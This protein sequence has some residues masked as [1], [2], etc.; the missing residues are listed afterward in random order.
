M[1]IQR[2]QNEFAVDVYESHCRI[3]LL[4]GDL[5][6]FNQCQTQ[7]KDLYD[8][9]THQH[10]DEF[11]A[12][13]LLYHV[14]LTTNDKYEAASLEITKLLGHAAGPALEHA[15]QVRHAV[16]LSDY[17]QFFRLHETVPNLG[18]CLTQCI[19]PTM[20]LRAMKR[21]TR[22]YRPSLDL[23]ACTQWLG[24]GSKDDCRRWIESC[25]GKT[26]ETT[27][28]TKESD[29]AIHEPQ[30]EEKNSLI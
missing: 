15:L 6:E 24:L 28:L 21:I 7:L 10:P 13:R 1:T 30:Q 11:A 27:F 22:A 20:R 19:V 18:N 2:I 4:E 17:L 29:G 5:N 14:F 25:G 16:A 26:D 8:T 3:A 9:V 12:Y 23:M